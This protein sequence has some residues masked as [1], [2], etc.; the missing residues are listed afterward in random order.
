MKNNTASRSPEEQTFDFFYEYIRKA[1]NIYRQHC[2][3][4]DFINRCS[5]R[6]ENGIGK[7]NLPYATL[8][9]EKELL[10]K[11]YE[12]YCKNEDCNVAYNDTMDFVIDHMEDFIER[13]S[14]KELSA[15]DKLRVVVVI[16]DGITSAAYV[17]NPKVQVEVI[18]VDQNYTSLKQKE[19][20]FTALTQDA[21]LHASDYLLSLPGYEEM[22][23]DEEEE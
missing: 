4:C 19:E 8:P 11:A 2:F 9:D 5:D 17:S 3:E 20:V 10:C 13:E 18:E 22:S 12:I 1:H 23:D 16:D 7:C 14:T 21:A 15:D 6:L